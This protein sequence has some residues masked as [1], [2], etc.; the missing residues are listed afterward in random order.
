MFAVAGDDVGATKGG[1]MRAA[2]GIG[3][4]GFVEDDELPGGVGNGID[5]WGGVKGTK[6]RKMGNS[7]IRYNSS[8]DTSGISKLSSSTHNLPLLAFASASSFA[9]VVLIAVVSQV[10]MLTCSSPY[11]ANPLGEL[12]LAQLLQLPAPA[13]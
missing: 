13:E 1:D 8:F 3:I 11:H 9:A 6:T 12:A 4:T 7:D 10:P 2:I 5:D